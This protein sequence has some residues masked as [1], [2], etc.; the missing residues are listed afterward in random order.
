MQV[1][2]V[3]FHGIVAAVT[4]LVLPVKLVEYQFAGVMLSVSLKLNAEFQD[5][6]KD[7]VKVHMEFAL[8]L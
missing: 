5:P 7:E 2:Y 1:S 4:A 3:G 8:V 6:S